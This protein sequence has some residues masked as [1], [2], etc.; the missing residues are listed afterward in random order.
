VNEEEHGRLA[1]KLDDLAEAFRA[2]TAVMVCDQQCADRRTI[3]AMELQALRDRLA[4]LE[5]AGSRRWHVLVEVVAVV[6]AVAALVVS[7]LL[8]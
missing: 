3:R 8:H 2:A 7:V 4:V 1:Q 5:G 6:T